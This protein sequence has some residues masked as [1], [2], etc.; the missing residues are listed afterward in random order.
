MGSS[1]SRVCGTGALGVVKLHREVIDPAPTPDIDST[2]G[3]FSDEDD[4]SHAD[5]PVKRHQ[6]VEI[7]DTGGTEVTWSDLICREKGIVIEQVIPPINTAYVGLYSSK[8]E[9]SKVIQRFD[10]ICESNG[11]PEST[12]CTNSD[13]GD[14]DTD[15]VTSVESA[16]SVTLRASDDLGN[17]FITFLFNE[18]INNVMTEMTEKEMSE[19]KVMDDTQVDSDCKSTSNA[20]EDL[21]DSSEFDTAEDYLNEIENASRRN[22]TF[23]D[24]F[25]TPKV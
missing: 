2:S 7:A 5:V 4:V 9:S 23:F 22:D 16:E 12:T 1:A 13:E 14:D 11:I 19:D 15:D 8:K 6:I 20:L 3:D 24:K 10:S 25:P 17:E 21:I 18:L